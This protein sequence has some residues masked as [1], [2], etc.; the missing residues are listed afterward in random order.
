M[1]SKIRPSDFEKTL[2]GH[3]G[4]VGQVAFDSNNLLAS[5][6]DDRTIKFWGT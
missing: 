5:G 3:L 2:V 1:G 6:S 4:E